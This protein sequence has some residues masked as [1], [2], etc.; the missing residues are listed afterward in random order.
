[1]GKGYLHDSVPAAVNNRIYT[2]NYSAFIY[3]E[4]ED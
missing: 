4:H 1:M 3:V 2:W